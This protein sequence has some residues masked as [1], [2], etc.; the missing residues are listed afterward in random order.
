PGGRRPARGW[1]WPDGPPP[2]QSRS[3][4]RGIS[5]SLHPGA[6]AGARRRRRQADELLVTRGVA[7]LEPVQDRDDELVDERVGGPF[8]QV[9]LDLSSEK[10]ARRIDGPFPELSCVVGELRLARRVTPQELEPVGILTCDREQRARADTAFALR[11]ADHELLGETIEHLLEHGPV[12]LFLPGEV[13]VDDE[14]GDARR[15]GDVLHGRRRVP[16]PGEGAAGA[17]ED[18]LRAGGAGQR[19]G[20]G[21]VD[22]GGVGTCHR[23]T[24]EYTLACVPVNGG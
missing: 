24:H 17:P 22:D 10:G 7:E 11:V 20:A 18:R 16:G 8:V 14:L 2:D 6:S 1:P 4:R 15:G 12:Q 5:S 3:A 19:A 9:G 13:P 21:G 23:Y